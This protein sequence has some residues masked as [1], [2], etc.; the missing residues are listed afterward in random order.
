MYSQ[1]NEEEI[2]LNYFGDYIGTFLDLGS[3]TGVELSNVRALAEKGWTGVMVEASPTVFKKLQ[4][5]YDGFDV[6]MYNC[7]IGDKTGIFEFHDNHHAV[8]TLY[9]TETQRWKGKQDFNKINVPCV[10]IN[11]FLNDLKIPTYDFISCDIEG[12]DLNV[13]S[14]IDLKKYGVKLICV[15]FNGKDKN[16]FDS[17]IIPQGFNLISKNSENLIYA[18]T[19]SGL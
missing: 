17:I 2:M 8:G 12:E 9:K 4:E 10:E 5:N 6:Q 14:R 15:E 16:K 3:Y 18:R 19:N 11:D 1:N 7:A 13:I